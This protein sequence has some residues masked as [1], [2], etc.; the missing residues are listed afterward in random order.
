MFDRNER[1]VVCNRRYM[2]L[3]QLP[4]EVVKPGRTLASLLEFRITNGS[5][6]RDP[7]EYRHELVAAMA[8][9]ETTTAEVKSITG[10]VVCVINRPMPD[11]GW[12]AT[13]EDITERREAERER[14]AMQEQQQRRA[15]IEHAIAAFRQR[16]EDHLR[17]VADSA[18]AMRS[19]ATDAVRQFR[20][21]LAARG[22][23]GVRPRTRPPPTSRPRRSPPTNCRARS[24]RSAASSRRPPTSCARRSPKRKCTNDE[25]GALAASRAED[26]RRRQADPQHRRPDQSAGAQRHDR[27]RARRRS[28]HAASRWSRPRSNRWRCRPPRRPRTSPTDRAV[29]S[30]TGSAVDAIGRIAEPHA[31]NRQL[32]HRRLCRRRSSRARR[33]A[34]S[35]RTS[36]APPTAPSWWSSVLGDVAGAATETRQSAESV[37]T[38]RRRSKPPPPNCAARSRASSPASPPD[39]PLTKPA[40]Q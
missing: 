6:S 34:R 32:R 13:H 39:H 1:L 29:Q 17:T 33:P 5:F 25:I 37:L 2:D 21:D 10:R 7:D 8:H 38:A 14:A 9:G 26:R 4:D 36:P 15:V 16:V 35:R 11:G 24:P 23:R 40:S 30:S 22:K 12:V 3:Y 18:M 19:T 20:P 31:G 28:R 27:G